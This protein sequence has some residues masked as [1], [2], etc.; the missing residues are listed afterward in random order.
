V[1]VTNERGT[2]LC[3]GVLIE[4]NYVLTAAHCI[5]SNG[6]SLPNRN[7]VV[8]AGIIKRRGDDYE[9]MQTVT[10]DTAHIIINQEWTG[11]SGRPMMSDVGNPLVTI[12]HIVEKFF[13]YL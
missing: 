13:I 5:N 7:V 8:K 9:Q 3:G 1:F 12:M 11:V 10:K 2:S 6:P 4:W